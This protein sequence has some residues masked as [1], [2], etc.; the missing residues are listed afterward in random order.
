MRSTT[1]VPVSV[2]WGAVVFTDG[3]GQVLML[4][5]T[6]RHQRWLLPGGVASEGETP[7]A[8]A[9][10]ETAEETG[11]QLGMAPRLLA[12]DT[13]IPRDSRV[14]M[15]GFMF[16]GGVTPAEIRLS[17]EHDTYQFA[18]F[19]AWPCDVP[20]EQRHRLASLQTARQRGVTLYLHNGR[21]PNS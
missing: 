21:V 10:R 18:A 5:D 2:V 15:V 20:E 14:P 17:S 13:L 9:V 7:W 12:V 4:R 11:I 1:G 19:D 3:S 16:D 6:S 8:A